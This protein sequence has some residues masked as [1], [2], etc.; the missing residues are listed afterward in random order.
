MVGVESHNNTLRALRYAK[1][2]YNLRPKIVTSDLSPNIIAPI[3][4]LFGSKV[5]QI[6]GYHV[7]QELNR[8]IRCDLLDYRTQLF[9][10]EIRELLALRRWIN[11]IQQEI[12]IT[13]KCSKGFLKAIPKVNPSHHNTQCCVATTKRIIT[14]ITIDNPNNF[15]LRLQR[16]LRDIDRKSQD[17]YHAFTEKIREKLPKGRMTLKGM[18]RL[19]IELLRKLKKLY[20]TFRSLLEVESI[21]FH[22][23]YWFLFIQPEKL[24]K[25]RIRALNAFIAKYPSLQEYRD[26]TLLV[27]E[28]YRKPIHDI[29][30]HQIDDL[31]IKP[32]YSKKLQT[33]ITTIK[34]YKKSILRFVEVFKEEPTLPKS[35]RA[36][37]EFFNKRFKA[38]FQH[39]L[40]RTKQAHLLAKLQLQLGCKVRFFSDN[41]E[42]I[43]RYKKLNV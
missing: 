4:Q 23:N 20:L 41:K 21:Q 10:T 37:M 17:V 25:R 9:S 36:N 42:L 26:M 7:M 33:A 43:Q 11:K 14:L 15:M 28:I 24:T 5:L 18:K 32:Y 30:G 13:E 22:K 8:G 38:P 1:E 19:K 2:K 6:D 16:V 40:N 29:D 39:G 35:C 27:G 3:R 34:K 31:I 12:E